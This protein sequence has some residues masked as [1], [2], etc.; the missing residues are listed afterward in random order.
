MKSPVME[1]GSW[2]EVSGEIERTVIQLYLRCVFQIHSFIISLT[3]LCG[4]HTWLMG[5]YHL[6][7]H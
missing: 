7:R 4:Y 1:E 3:L 5:G 6:L 2:G